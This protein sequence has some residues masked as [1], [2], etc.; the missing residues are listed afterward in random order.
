MS[1]T[2]A[3]IIGFLGRAFIAT[4]VLILAFAAFQL[5][6]TGWHEARAQGALA[7]E[8]ESAR[9]DYEA[10]V[11]NA[12]STTTTTTDPDSDD[13]VVTTIEPEPIVLAPELAEELLPKEGEAMGRIIIPKINVEKEIIQGTRRD[14]LRAGPGHYPDTPM[15]GQPG[16]AAIAGHRTTYGAPFGD[17]DLLVP[18]DIIE[19]E[20]VQGT[21]FY[22]VQGHKD[23]NGELRGHFI[24]DKYATEVLNDEGDNRLT[25]TACHPKRSAAQRIIVTALL[26][27]EPAPVIA[28]PTTTSTTVPDEQELAADEAVAETQNEELDSLGWQTEETGP[29][30]TWALITALVAAGG[31][32]VGRI[33]R[34]WPAYAMFVVPFLASLFVCFGHLDRLIPAF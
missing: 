20:T 18:G 7:D 17:L 15:P 10:E 26:T 14:D 19:V 21:F 2:T 27:S 9:A 22:E 23:A 3:I 16:N 6:G 5:W 11:G 33:W 31:W 25:L 13:P 32:A 29:T 12:S 4:G 34:R 30:V 28:A 24:V 8:F 1:R